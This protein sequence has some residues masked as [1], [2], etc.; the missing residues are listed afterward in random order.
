[1]QFSLSNQNKWLFYVTTKLE[2]AE[3]VILV[4]GFFCKIL[5]KSCGSTSAVM[6]FFKAVRVY[7]LPIT[8]GRADR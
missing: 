4:A 2:T 7:A 6:N 5:C 8:G 1:M 3:A